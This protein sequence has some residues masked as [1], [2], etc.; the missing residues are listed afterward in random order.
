MKTNNQDT[1]LLIIGVFAIFIFSI[2]S[3]L[4]SN[5]TI[6]SSLAISPLIVGII[7]GILFANTVKES[8]FEKYNQAIKFS[9]KRLLRIGIIL[10]GFRLSFQDIAEVGFGGVFV[11]LFIIFSTFILGYFIGVKILKLDREIS[12]LCSSG[13]AICGAAAVMA[14]SS[15]VKNESYKSAIA[16]SFVVIFGSIGMF[17]LPFLYKIGLIPLD[18]NQIG[19]YFGAVL[20]EVANVVAAGNMVSEEATN[21]AIIVKMIRVMFLVPFLLLL[22]YFL[23]KFP[24][25]QNSK[26]KSKIIIPWFAVIF[27]FVVAFNSFKFLNI[28]ILSTINYIDMIFLTM[29]MFALGLNT[30]IK[31]FKEVGLKPFYLTLLLFLYLSIIGYFLVLIF[32]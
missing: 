11:A 17:L 6:V 27:I 2:I 23:I 30:N 25:S 8:L 4:I 24:S 15:V 14:T 10:Y 21:S 3:I 16:V 5:L 13:A 12:I 19:V 9:A 32:V 28:E 7:L 31:K 26:T 20:H 1:K 18:N 22:S 29:A